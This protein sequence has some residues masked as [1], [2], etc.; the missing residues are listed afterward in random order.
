[1]RGIFDVTKG[2]PM[3]LNANGFLGLEPPE[4]ET[5]NSNYNFLTTLKDE[6]MIDHKVIGLSIH[7]T[8]M[9]L[10]KITFGGYDPARVT[11]N[12]T[13]INTKDKKTWDLP[14]TEVRYGDQVYTPKI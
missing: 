12:I 13:Y 9:N 11:G 14:F 6:K 8:D 10:S 1:M 2:G 5:L 4:S 7:L 3:I